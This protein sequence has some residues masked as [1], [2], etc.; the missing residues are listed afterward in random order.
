M[1]ADNRKIIYLMEKITISLQ[2][3]PRHRLAQNQNDFNTLSMKVENC[4]GASGGSWENNVTRLGKTLRVT[5]GPPVRKD[6]I[7]AHELMPQWFIR[8]RECIC[9]I[10]MPQEKAQKSWQ[11][12]HIP[13][14]HTLFCRC[15]SSTRHK[16]LAV[17]SGT[18]T[19]TANPLAVVFMLFNVVYPHPV[20]NWGIW[21]W[22]KR[23]TKP[24]LWIIVIQL[25][26]FSLKPYMP[27]R[28]LASVVASELGPGGRCLGA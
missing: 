18:I 21:G 19:N 17:M 16:S 27:I 6:R 4:L 7:H 10:R 5:N 20:Y 26:M 23:C 11:C 1:F 15:V 9:N 25:R 12:K 22:L 8:L 2:Y 14:F 13:G 28:A 24:T 3:V